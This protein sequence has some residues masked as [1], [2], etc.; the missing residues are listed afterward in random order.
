[1]I[2]RRSANDRGRTRLDWLISQHTFSF[3]DYYDPAHMG[4]RALRVINEDRVQPGAGFGMHGHRDMEILTYVLDGAL[5]HQDSLGTGSIITP[6]EGQ[7]M[8]AGTG[9]R[10]SEYNHSHTEPVHFL[11]IWIVPERQGLAPGYEQKTLPQSAGEHGW[12]LLASRDGRQGSIT[13]H[14]DIA[15]YTARLSAGESVTHHLQPQR[16]A[17]IQVARGR[18]ELHGLSLQ[19][20]DGAAISAETVLAVK[21]QEGAETLLFDLA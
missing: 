1:M 13:V 4:F 15:I 8:S 9:I 16:Y 20:G 5:A 11:Q 2:T 7:R 3:G 6:G 19:A 21:A 14:Q 17:W 12:T 18:V 10:H